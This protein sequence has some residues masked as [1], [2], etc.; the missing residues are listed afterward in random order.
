MTPLAS[1][2]LRIHFSVPL[3]FRKTMRNDALAGNCVFS[4]AW[5]QYIC[6]NPFRTRPAIVVKA[7]MSCG[8]SYGL[9]FATFARD[10]IPCRLGIA[11]FCST[12]HLSCECNH[13]RFRIPIASAR[14]C[15]Y[16]G[17][18]RSLHYFHSRYAR[19]QFLL[20]PPCQYIQHCRHL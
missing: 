2:R 19:F 18:R 10:F 9:E 3:T 15:Q 12:W 20:L 7:T 11:D 14:D 8:G 17:I 6:T 5:S 16:L 1:W 13:R 4:G